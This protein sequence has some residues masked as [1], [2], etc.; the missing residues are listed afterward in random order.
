MK[1]PA[2]FIDALR[3]CLGLEPLP[4]SVVPLRTNKDP[5]TKFLQWGESMQSNTFMVFDDKDFHA[6]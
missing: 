1:T 4:D 5:M 6:S 2:A 3:E